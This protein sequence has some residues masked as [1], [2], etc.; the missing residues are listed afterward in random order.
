MFCTHQKLQACAKA[1]AFDRTPFPRKPCIAAVNGVL[2]AKKG[3]W[4]HLHMKIKRPHFHAKAPVLKHILRG[5]KGN[6]S[7][8][9]GAVLGIAGPGAE[10]S[11]GP[12]AESSAG[13]LFAVSTCFPVISFQ[14][15]S[16]AGPLLGYQKRRA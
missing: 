13:A 14:F 2:T 6:V 4:L 15:F 5:S 8:P 11:A 9:P 7:V 1:C 12:G 3:N 10:S 16:D